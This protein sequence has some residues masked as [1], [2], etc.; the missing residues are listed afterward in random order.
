MRVVVRVTVLRVCH[1][2]A[3]RSH[4]YRIHTEDREA[5]HTVL[6]GGV[7]LTALDLAEDREAV[8][9]VL[10]AQNSSLRECR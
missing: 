5:V 9:T 3:T 8:H 1:Q 4:C 7:G 10:G 2:A 6:R